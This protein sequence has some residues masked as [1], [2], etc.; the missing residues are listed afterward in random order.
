MA[1]KRL[2]TCGNWPEPAGADPVIAEDLTKRFGEF[3]RG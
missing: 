3:H 2:D 1:D